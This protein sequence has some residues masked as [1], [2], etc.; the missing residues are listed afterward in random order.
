MSH[1]IEILDNNTVEIF[2]EGSDVPFLRQPTWPDQSPWADAAEARGW[3][4][5]F[6]EAAT[7]ADAPFAPSGPGQERKSKPT[8]E[9]I[10]E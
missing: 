4:E 9:Q 3:A 2:A 6:I 1:R 8:P 10:A 5:M 7:D